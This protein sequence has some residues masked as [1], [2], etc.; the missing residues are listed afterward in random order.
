M[1]IWL[2]ICAAIFVL[3]TLI[4]VMKLQPFI[5]FLVVSL[6]LGIAASLTT[7]QTIAA[8]QKGIGGT[9]GSIIPIIILG[10]MLGKMVAKSRATFV[11][12]EYFVGLFG[13]KN[14]P[15]AFMLI[16]FIVGLPLFFSVAFLL[17]TPLV[18]STAERYNLPPVYLG[19][20]MLASLSITQGFLPPHPAPYYLVTHLPGAEMGTTLGYGILISIPA[21][22][23]SG[24]LFGKTLK[25]IPATPMSFVE[26][27]DS[28]NN[29]SV[30]ISLSILLLPVALIAIKSFVHLPGIDLIGEPM[31]A[32]LISVFA[33]VYF[34]GL[35]RG[36][37]W[38]EISNW[39]VD[40]IKDVAPLM[41]TFGGAGAFKEILQEMHVGD[42]MHEMTQ[43]SAVNPLIIAWGI[44]AVLRIVTG[45]STV[46]GIT[47]AGLILPLLA[48]SGVNPNLL[49]LSIGAG[50][51]VLSHVNDAG[52]WLYK[53]Y[54]GVSIKDSLRTWTIM[55]T[56]LAVVG[57]LG[58]LGLELVL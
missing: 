5:A 16:G 34:L 9:L 48:S 6:G 39:L 37:S 17:L 35:R 7:E 29:P 13:P 10:S 21:M 52:F 1:S 11:L 25:N 12:S 24:W 56:I 54:F 23:A 50:S 20:P 58:V 28:G 40:S 36:I 55:E 38:P 8:M 47:T 45:S 26:S 15:I 14:L 3:V 51:M 30:G 42:A 43:G 19:I 32:L 57:L 33:A 41:L 44:A 22:L 46:S 27:D 4:S 31:V 49:A 2:L 18:L 53:E